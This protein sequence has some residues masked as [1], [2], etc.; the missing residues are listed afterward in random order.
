MDTVAKSGLN[1]VL[2]NFDNGDPDISLTTA[3]VV[4]DIS[5]NRWAIETRY[6]TGVQLKQTVTPLPGAERHA[7]GCLDIIGTITPVF[8][9]AELL[10]LKKV[11]P[12]LDSCDIILVGESRTEFA[13]HFSGK[14][15]YVRVPNENITLESPDTF[16]EADWVIGTLNDATVILNGRALLDDGSFVL[17]HL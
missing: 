8:C 13:L 3:L 16:P 2:D 6:V 17:G 7:L 14:C 1:P 15:S 10:G 5:G 9:L 12:D 11:L 4:F